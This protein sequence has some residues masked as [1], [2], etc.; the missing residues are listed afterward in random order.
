MSFPHTT[1]LP[2]NNFS[3]WFYDQTKYIEKLP[4]YCPECNNE[5]LLIEYCSIC[6]SRILDFPIKKPVS[7]KISN[8]LFLPVGFFVI[9][10]SY[11]AVV[12]EYFNQTIGEIDI[13]IFLDNIPIFSPPLIVVYFST[14]LAKKFYIKMKNTKKSRILNRSRG[15]YSLFKLANAILTI[16][17]TGKPRDVMLKQFYYIPGKI[18]TQM[19]I[20]KESVFGDQ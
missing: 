15:A 16:T 3:E 1:V 17:S 20:T 9:C 10:A 11:I 19:T 2:N 14:L 8:F 7:H 13:H 12:N 5:V 6:E 18:A 4:F